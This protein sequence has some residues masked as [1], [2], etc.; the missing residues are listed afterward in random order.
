MIEIFVWTVFILLSLDVRVWAD[1]RVSRS[2]S[3]RS[4]LRSH[5][6]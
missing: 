3:L 6:L 2:T 5:F 4:M 1:E